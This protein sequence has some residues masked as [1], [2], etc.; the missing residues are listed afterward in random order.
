MNKKDLIC[1]FLDSKAE[2]IGDIA[3]KIW[4]FAELSL[5]EYKSADLYCKVLED[6]G[7]VVTRNLCDI[8]TS[9]LGEYGSGRPV[10]GILAEYDALSGLSQQAFC[11]EKK[12]ANLENPNG[13][14]C[15]H[16]ILG[17]GSLGAALGIKKYLED[18]PGNGTVR[19]YGCPGEEAGAAKAFMARD[20]VWKDLDCALTWHPD[21]CNEVFTG[22]CNCSIQVQ[23]IF[24]G[25][26]AHAAGEPH[27]GRSAL[28]AVELMNI[29]IQFLREHMKDGQRVHYAITNSGGISP[30]V[31][32][33]YSSVLYYIRS[34]YVEDALELEKRVD[35]IAE[36]AALMTETTYKKEFIDGSSDTVPNKTLERVCNENLKLVGCPVYT[37]DEYSFA[38]TLAKTYSQSDKVCSIAA[39]YDIKAKEEVQELQSK[40][41][42]NIN[43]F[44]A[45]Y[46]EGEPFE[47]GSTDVG[48]VSHLTPTIQ[49]HIAAW[50]NGCPAHSWQSVS[51]AGSSIGKKAAITAGKVLA[52]TAIDIF[53]NNNILDSA[54][55]EHKK[56]IGDKPFVSP[57]PAGAKPVIPTF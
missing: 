8:S 42:H 49:L 3:D 56:R 14:G 10:I 7:F 52:L 27:L 1:N 22:S 50:P 48:D 51:S 18:N 24:E 41:A 57:I 54:K 31:V 9:F 29:G 32:Q 26:A 46:Y 15:G 37:T 25:K 19:F 11:S 2:L 44:I 33:A 17:A 55:S 39:A 45:P 16:N 47:P 40:C 35:K 43:E 6:E 30:N 20:G 5:Q 4:E 12:V 13:H 23:Y 21:D 36:G 34:N 53:E 28:D 38:D